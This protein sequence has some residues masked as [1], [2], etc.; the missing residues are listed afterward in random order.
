MNVDEVVKIFGS[1]SEMPQNSKNGNKEGNGFPILAL[2]I[3][4]GVGYLFY[5]EWKRRKNLERE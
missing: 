1:L 2:L 3:I 5:R 4:G